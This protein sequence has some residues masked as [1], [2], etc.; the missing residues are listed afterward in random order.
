MRSPWIFLSQPARLQHVPNI[1]GL[2]WSD[3]PTTQQNHAYAIATN[4]ACPGSNYGNGGRVASISSRPG[5]SEHCGRHPDRTASIGP[6]RASMRRP[7]PPGDP[8][9]D[10][11][12]AHL[13]LREVAARPETPRDVRSRRVQPRAP[14]WVGGALVHS[15]AVSGLKCSVIFLHCSKCGR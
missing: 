14:Q 10:F 2:W 7:G 5:E 9:G 6:L 13:R 11:A 4:N 12:Q 3:A 8:I 15:D 1:R